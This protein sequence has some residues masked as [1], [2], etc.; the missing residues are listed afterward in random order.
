[1]PFFSIIIPLYNKGAHIIST[2]ESVNNQS[3]TDYE[4][5][6]INDGSTDNGMQKVNTLKNPKLKIYNR[7]NQGVSQARNF[8]MQEAS[9]RY[10]AF[11][12]ADD[13]WHEHHLKDLHKLIQSYPNCG[14]Y[15]T[16]YIFD[17]GNDFMVKPYFP[18]LPKES[19]WSGVISDYFL[20]SLKYR[21]AWTS[22]I[23]IPRDTLNTIGFFDESITLGAGED[24]D[25]WT[26]IALENFVA[27]TKN[28]SVT[29]NISA[30]NRISNI[31]T[32]KRK[33]MK[34]DKFYEEEKTNL[35]L[36][37]FNDMC[38]AELAIKHK[39]IGDSDQYNFYIANLNLNNIGWK[40]RLLINFP[41]AT[42][43][44]LWKFKQWL[45]ANKIDIHS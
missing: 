5:I 36:K 3:Y 7:T 37:K 26:R 8:A 12:D 42:L 41:G 18:T 2:L 40:K 21:I 24:T 31:S 22:A 14:L 39:I 25:Y 30:N 4:I 19:N 35:S 38:R 43:R 15:A 20:A 45:K 34:L 28:I 44:F 17:Y 6:L 33:F 29:Y 13:L 32:K 1:M 11:L 23:A 27:F 10:L 16:N 9:G